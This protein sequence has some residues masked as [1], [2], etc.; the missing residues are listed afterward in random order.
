MLTRSNRT[1]LT[2]LL[3]AAAAALAPM[4]MSAQPAPGRD[5]P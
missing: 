2:A 3:M 5:V 4:M 1:L